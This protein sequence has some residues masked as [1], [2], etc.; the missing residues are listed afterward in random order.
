MK[1]IFLGPPGAGKGTQAERNVKDFGIPQLSTGDILRA[2]RKSGT[3]LGKLAEKYMNS[4]ELVPDKLIIDMIKNELAKPEYSKGFILDGFPRT[5]SQAIELDKLMLEMRARIDA[6][7]ILEA[8]DEVLIE[9]LTARRTCPQCGKS[10]HL[11][12][13]PPKQ[14]E[15]CDLDGTA[16][17]QRKDDTEETV[18]NRLKVYAESTFPLIDYYMSQGKAAFIDGVGK[19]EEVYQR[20]KEG[21]DRLVFNRRKA[22]TPF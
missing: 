20:I 17:I 14:D 13:A 22:G 1:I 4:G 9:R 7:M 2:N 5:V 12:F 3:D 18:K 6:A 16:L 10:Y 21:L 15:I 19:Q 8:P 11:I